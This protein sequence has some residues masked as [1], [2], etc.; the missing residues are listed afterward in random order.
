MLV[1]EDACARCGRL[2][3][4]DDLLLWTTRARLRSYRAAAREPERVVLVAETGA[5]VPAE[6]RT[7]E[8]SELVRRPAVNY[9]WVTQAFA[10]CP[11]CH[12]VVQADAAR[13]HDHDHRRA[14]VILIAALAVFALIWAGFAPFTSNWIAAFWRNGA[15]GR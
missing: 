4:T 7:S 3:P 15:G 8:P 12:P 6:T 1:E 10:L 11:D 2:T 9:R 14:W 13:F 5:A